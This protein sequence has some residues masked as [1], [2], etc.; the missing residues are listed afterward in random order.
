[1]KSLIFHILTSFKAIKQIRKKEIK[2]A[3]RW[4]FKKGAKKSKNGKS[5]LKV[6]IDFV[7]NTFLEI[8]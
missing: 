1:M 7:L 3:K 5:P 2:E 4:K 6:V 8:L